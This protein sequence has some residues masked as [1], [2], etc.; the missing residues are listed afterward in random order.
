MYAAI[1][2]L[3]IIVLTNFGFGIQLLSTNYFVDGNISSFMSRIKLE[4]RVGL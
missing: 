1:V 4:S 3:I 2:G